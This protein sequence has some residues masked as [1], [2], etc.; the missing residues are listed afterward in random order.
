[1]DLDEWMMSVKR[2][3]NMHC[4]NNGIL[5]EKVFG[6]SLNHANNGPFVFERAPLLTMKGAKLNNM[7]T[8][9]SMKL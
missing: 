1:M 3:E 4:H 8:P 5:K 9:S 2:M 6:Y 7:D